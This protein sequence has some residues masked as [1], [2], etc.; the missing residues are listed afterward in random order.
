MG[1]EHEQDGEGAGSGGG[2]NVSDSCRYGLVGRTCVGFREHH[3]C[4]D[5]MGTS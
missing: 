3:D 1:G 4:L 5:G 2:N